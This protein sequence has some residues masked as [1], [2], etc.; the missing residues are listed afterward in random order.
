MKQR[1]LA[2][3][4]CLTSIFLLVSNCV[5]AA[6]LECCCQI[7]CNYVRALGGSPTTIEVDQ[8]WDLTEISSCDAN[9]ACLKVK[10]VFLTYTDEWTGTGCRTQEKCIISFLYGTDNPKLGIL[11]EFRDKVLTQTP[12]GQ[13]LIKLYYEWSPVIVEAMEQDEEFKEDVKEMIQGLVPIMGE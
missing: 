11:R 10:N 6:D 13:E 8:C 5:T 7:T 12:E 4:L 3:A 1:F 9:T 2:I